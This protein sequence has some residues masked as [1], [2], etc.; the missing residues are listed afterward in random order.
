ME[1]QKKITGNGR[2]AEG[3]TPKQRIEKKIQEQV[4]ERISEIENESGWECEHIDESVKEHELCQDDILAAYIG[5]ENNYIVDGA[6]VSCDLMSSKNVY[7]AYGD[8]IITMYGEGGEA[9]LKAAS[10]KTS[11][12]NF[13]SA[14]TDKEEVGRLSAVHALK[15]ADNGLRF[16]TVTDCLCQRDI[17]E[18]VKTGKA[19]L[20]SMGN[21]RMIKTK[22]IGEIINDKE[23]MKMAQQYGTCYC[24][25]KPAEE[26][27]NPMC[28]EEA[29]GNFN[30]KL[31]CKNNSHH[32][33]MEWS[34]ANGEKEGITMLSTLLCTRGGII[35]VK[36]S[37]QIYITTEVERAIMK[38][39]DWRDKKGISNKEVKDAV[40]IIFDNMG[41]EEIKKYITVRERLWIDLR[42]YGY[43]ETATAAIMGNVAVESPGFKTDGLQGSLTE[44]KSGLGMGLFQWSFST[45]QNGLYSL[46][47]E[48]GL[49]WDDYEVQIAFMIKEVEEDQRY[50]EVRKENLNNMSLY[51]AVEVFAIEYEEPGKLG[52]SERNKG[53]DEVYEDFA[54]WD[55][56]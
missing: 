31:S 40:N 50:A 43:N 45:R 11:V 16:A 9:E 55:I 15:Q 49:K 3:V 42:C 48:M 20:V 44:P 35:T 6:I 30:A 29:Y 23:R 19:S 33:T 54:G 7:I 13:F 4:R 14:N 28:M 52:L 24:L 17:E 37:G 39:Q 12:E 56:G 51:E 38:I 46:A 22:D 25:M 2:R 21:C 53:A 10:E 27:V 26:W 1:I 47:E 32:K 41:S 5:E 34:T 18:G 36:W 8:G